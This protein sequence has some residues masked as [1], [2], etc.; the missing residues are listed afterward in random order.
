MTDSGTWLC[1]EIIFESNNRH[2]KPGSYAVPGDKAHA[3]V[4]PIVA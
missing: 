2:L 1:K 3:V 4:N